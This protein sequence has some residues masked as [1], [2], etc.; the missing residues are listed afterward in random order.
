MAFDSRALTPVMYAD[1][2]TFWQYRTADSATAV[3]T[4]GYFNPAAEQLRI[5]DWILCQMADDQTIH[6]VAG[7]D[8]KTVTLTTNPRRL[9]LSDSI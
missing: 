5:N 2:F 3:T 8:G 4:T 7:H 6:A 1:G 9:T